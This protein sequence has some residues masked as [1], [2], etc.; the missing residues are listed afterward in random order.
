MGVQLF[1]ASRGSIVPKNKEP[2]FGGALFQNESL[3]LVLR[4]RV[5]ALLTGLAWFILTRDLVLLSRLLVR[6][7]TLLTAAALATL[8]L[9]AALISDFGLD[10][11]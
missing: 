5:T 3:L 4:V 1:K 11:S 9:L 6:L 8:V 10:C 7:A 2:R